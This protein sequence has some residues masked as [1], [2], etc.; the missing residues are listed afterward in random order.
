MKQY[1]ISKVAVVGAGVM[2]S[3]IAQVFAQQGFSVIVNDLNEDIL[4]KAKKRI[5]NN[6][7]LFHQEGILSKENLKEVAQNLTF[8]SRMDE[9]NGVDMVVEAI[10]EQIKLKQALFQKLDKMFSPEV[11]L[12]T[13][14]SGISI[15]LIA[16]ATKNPDR[17][18]GMHWW[19]P[20][21]IIPV[22]EIIKGE[23]TKEEIVE[24]VRELVIRLKK[25]P[26]L[27]KKD[28]PGFLGNR[29]QYALMREAVHLLEE[30]VASAEDIDTMV[31]AGFGFKF[32][33]IGPLETIDMAGM[34]I[35]YNVSQYL[36]KELDS[37]EKPQKLVAEK[38]KQEKLGM[39]TGE[40]FYSYKEIDSNK[41]NQ[42]R[43]KKYIKLL[44]ELGYY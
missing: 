25:K 34:D 31:K 2:G 33:I 37:S 23:K 9:I 43:V 13:N 15:S 17:V 11:I 28:I 1:S 20:P 7:Y 21:Y 36:Y 5:E 44:K 16:S 42:Q 29:M 35:F 40:G 6:L 12:A 41:L 26:I 14:T 4:K 24:A 19:N 30:K 38:V 39:K 18:V 8:S 10:S 27:V 3:G 32:P 22:V